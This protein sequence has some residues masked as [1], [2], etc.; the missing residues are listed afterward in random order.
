MPRPTVMISVNSEILRESI[1]K[2]QPLASLEGILG[3]SRQAINGWL[4]KNRIPPRQLSIIAKE[5]K[6]NPL[7]VTQ[8]TSLPKSRA[9]ILFRTNRNVA[10]PEEVRSDVLETSED[11]FNLETLADLELS[12]ANL[13][14]KSESPQVMADLILTN[15]KLDFNQISLTSVITALK[16]LNI[17]V[18]FYDFG[19]K[20]VD[21]KAQA[22]CVRKDDKRAIFV[23]S[24]E[25][26]EDVLWRILHETCHLFCG[27]TETSIED[28]KFCNETASQILTPDKFFLEQKKELKSLLAKD[29]SASPFILENLASKLSASFIGV[30]LALKKHKIIESPTERYLWRVSN[31]RKDLASRVASKINP[32]EGVDPVKFWKMALED[33]NKS[34]FLALQ[35]LVR[36]GL[37][38][39]KISVRR[40]AELLR[41]DEL[42]AQKLTHIWTAQYETQSNL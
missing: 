2:R 19:A 9:H 10:V 8:I 16:K 38:L 25:L 7:E 28:E 26:V 6:F 36:M 18:L 22:V 3:V 12:T 30:L 14:V 34:N 42:D 15:L 39:K 17:H 41:V 31:N 4:S 27:H 1:V 13:T 40:A 20:F 35:H 23:N 24:Y 33:S 11:F 21:A 29:I 32:P 37:I 5:L